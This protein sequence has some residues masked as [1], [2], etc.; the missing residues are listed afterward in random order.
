MQDYD[1]GRFSV[2]Y[3]TKKLLPGER[4]YSF[5]EREC[6]AIVYAVKKF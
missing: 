2:A 3:A 6:L 5:I 4:N 1:D